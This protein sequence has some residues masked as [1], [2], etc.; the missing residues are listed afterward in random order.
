MREHVPVPYDNLFQSTLTVIFGLGPMIG[1]AM[2]SGHLNKIISLPGALEMVFK[3]TSLDPSVAVSPEKHLFST[4]SC[5]PGKYH[6]AL[7]KLK[8][9]TFRAK[10]LTNSKQIFKLSCALKPWTNALASRR[11]WTQVQLA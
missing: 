4:W 2:A 1:Q 5:K 8:I 10:V 7:P 3:E 9:Q 6:T 11:K